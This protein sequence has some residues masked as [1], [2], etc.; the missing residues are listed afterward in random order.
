MDAGIASGT[1]GLRARL[2]ERFPTLGRGGPPSLFLPAGSH[3]ARDRAG[4]NDCYSAANVEG[5]VY[6]NRSIAALPGRR[7]RDW[8]VRSAANRRLPA[9]SACRRGRRR[10]GTVAPANRGAGHAVVRSA[11]ATDKPLFKW[12][13]ARGEWRE[14]DK[15]L[16][17]PLATRHSPLERSAPRA[18][19]CA[20]LSGRKRRAVDCPGD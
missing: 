11:A 9:D 4:A 16:C 14:K 6:R 7:R 17:S 20:A 19:R 8:P 3:Q 15:L 13:V 2:R 5:S 1:A 10:I 18:R 12:R